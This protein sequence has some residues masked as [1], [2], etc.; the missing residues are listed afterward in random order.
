MILEEMFMIDLHVHSVWSDGELTPS[1]LVGTAKGLGLQGIALTDHDTQAGLSELCKAGEEQGLAVY[2]GVEVSC[3]QTDGTQLHMLIYDIPKESIGIIEKL[4][5]PI[6]QGRNRAVLQAAECLHQQGYPV[7]AE[8]VLAMAGPGGDL[9]K[10]FI[11]ALLMDAGLCEELYGPLY[12]QLFKMDEDGVPGPAKLSFH[13]ADPA[14]AVR[15]AVGAGAK[16]VLAH[17][18]QYGNYEIVPSLVKLGL[19]GIEA[20]HPMHKEEDVRRCLELAEIYHLA[21]TGGSD[22]HGRRYGEGETLG[23]RGVELAPLIRL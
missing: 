7:S 12:R 10:Q 18:G 1:Q 11:M 2:G 23:C 14:E 20:Y 5:N 3:V 17:P 22:Y 13:N 21:I 8:R 19:W 16:A 6:R 9:C 15:C 4:C